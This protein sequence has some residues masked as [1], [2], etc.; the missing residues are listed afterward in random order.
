M[1]KQEKTTNSIDLHN[2]PEVVQCMHA[3]QSRT[4]I[5]PALTPQIHRRK[6]T[7][8]KLIQFNSLKW[9][10][11]FLAAAAAVIVAAALFQNYREE[12]Y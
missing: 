8:T 1:E 12:N 4:K 2:D 6:A 11:F 7:K 9:K 3:N 5:P 10:V